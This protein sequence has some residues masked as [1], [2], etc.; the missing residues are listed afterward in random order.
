MA[1]IT[2]G[3]VGA[4]AGNPLTITVPGTVLT[5]H[6]MYVQTTYPSGGDP[7][8]LG[9]TD[10]T[11]WTE[12]TAAARPGLPSGSAQA[13]SVHTL[14]VRKFTGAVPATIEF[15]NVGGA[16]VRAGGLVWGVWSGLDETTAAYATTYDTS[17]TQ[18]SRD[19]PSVT[20]PAGGGLVIMGGN[21]DNLPIDAPRNYGAYTERVYVDHDDSTVSAFTNTQYFASKEDVAAG[22]TGPLP[23]TW[24]SGNNATKVLFTVTIGNAASGSAPVLSSPTPSGTIGTTTTATIG[25][26]TDYNSGGT[27]Y[28]VVDTASLSGITASQIKAGQNASSAAAV[29]SGSV[30]VSSTTPSVGVTGL[31]AGTT[32]N[33][34][35]VHNNPTGDSNI[36]TGSFTT[37]AAT[38]SSSPPLPRGGRNAILMLT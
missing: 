13:G 23:F 24:G 16:S 7:G 5:G 20:V 29:A 15:T 35:C 12:L 3:S 14:W 18:T 17:G 28:A 27:F 6:T 38:P 37:A 11:G 25:A 33:Y 22:A 10:T 4:A 19:H 31:A 9:P 8:W 30:T 21:W 32:Y 1:Y 36:V 2:G 34:A 26:T